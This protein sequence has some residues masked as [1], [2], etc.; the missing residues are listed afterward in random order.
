M[1]SAEADR[2]KPGLSDSFDYYLISDI[3]P[4]PVNRFIVGGRNLYACQPGV[5]DIRAIRVVQRYAEGAVVDLSQNI[6]IKG[7]ALCYIG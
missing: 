4:G 3:D 1:F 7:L 5:V 6:V 2:A